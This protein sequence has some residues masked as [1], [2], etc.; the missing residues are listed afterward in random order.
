MNKLPSLL[1]VPLVSCAGQGGYTDLP[2]EG[3]FD[4]QLG[5][6]YDTTADIVVRDSTEDP[7]PGAYNI[8]YLNG[9]QTQPGQS[10]SWAGSDFDVLLRDGAG[11]P[12]ADPQWPDEY[13]L[14]PNT[15]ESRSAILAVLGPQIEGCASTGFDAVEFDNLDTWT[16]FDGIS[17]EGALELAASYVELAHANGLA[18]GQKNASEMAAAGR[19]LGFDF[20]ITEECAAWEECGLFTEQYGQRVL[21]VE[22]PEGLRG[23]FADLCSSPDR[24]ERAILRDRALAPSGETGHLLLACPTE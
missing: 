12:V 15:Q 8:C 3:T 7:Q 11:E 13:I 19:R 22:Y 5:G 10:Q 1:L 20:A 23:S 16:R 2:T 24:A 21:Q 9:F 6:A 17:R 14:N 4:Y 18:A